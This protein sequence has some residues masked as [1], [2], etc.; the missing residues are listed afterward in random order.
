MYDAAH[1]RLEQARLNRELAQQTLTA[2]GI[3][4]N[5]GDIDILMLNIYE[6]AFADAG[7]EI[8]HAEV[9][10]LIAEAMLQVATGRSL[11]VDEV[12]PPLINELPL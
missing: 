1:L 3:S 9:D 11:I 4:F 10:V 12:L 7:L 6:Q 8:I 2:G 5:S